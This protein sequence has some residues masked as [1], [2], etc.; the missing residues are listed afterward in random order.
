MILQNFLLRNRMSDDVRA[1]HDSKI[2]HSAKLNFTNVIENKFCFKSVKMCRTGRHWFV[3]I[4][5][6]QGCR[7]II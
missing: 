5:D 3:S 2:I 1:R 4:H 6:F 7:S